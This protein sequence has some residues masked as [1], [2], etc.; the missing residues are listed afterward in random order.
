MLVQLQQIYIGDCVSEI[1]QTS[2]TATSIE[3]HAFIPTSGTVKKCHG[4]LVFQGDGTALI[5]E[6]DNR[7]FTLSMHCQNNFPSK[8]Q[9]S[10]LDIGLSVGTEVSARCCFSNASLFVWYATSGL[11]LYFEVSPWLFIAMN[12]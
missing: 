2:S 7:V 4:L 1:F 9:N 12:M 10:D 5:F 11:Q 3:H 8:K 6:D